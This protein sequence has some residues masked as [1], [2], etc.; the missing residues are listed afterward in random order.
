MQFAIIKN[1][2]KE[3]WEYG[4]TRGKNREP[5]TERGVTNV[6]GTGFR[7]LL[8]FRFFIFYFFF[9]FLFK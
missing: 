9:L 3:V 7:F 4:A 6:D 2:Q 1:L 5:Q 8:V